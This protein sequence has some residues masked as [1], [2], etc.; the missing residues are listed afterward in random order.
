MADETKRPLVLLDDVIVD[1]SGTPFVTDG[2]PYT[3][4]AQATSFGGGAVSV[5]TSFDAGGTWLT[6]SEGGTP[7]A[8]TENTVRSVVGLSGGLQ[9][10]GTL[11]GSTDASG[12]DVVLA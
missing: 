2:G 8:F 9:I 12:V 3:L 7:I 1:G 10:R 6:L 11:T 5:E 4:F